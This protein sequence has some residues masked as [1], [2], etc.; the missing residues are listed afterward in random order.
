MSSMYYRRLGTFSV[1]VTMRCARGG[2]VACFPFLTSNSLVPTSMWAGTEG[3]KVPIG[4]E[5]TVCWEI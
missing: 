2:T 5:A 1:H 3:K 4:S